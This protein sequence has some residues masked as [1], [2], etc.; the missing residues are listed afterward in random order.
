MTSRLRPKSIKRI[1]SPVAS[2]FMTSDT[3]KVSTPA[4]PKEA[5]K[6][7]TAELLTIVLTVVVTVAII[8]V[9]L[10]YFI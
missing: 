4:M 1:P 9:L 5:T 8:F 2:S 3:I 7:I 10:L 6:P